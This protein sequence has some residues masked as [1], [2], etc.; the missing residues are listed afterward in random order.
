MDMSG[1]FLESL[2]LRQ[3]PELMCDQAEAQNSQWRLEALGFS[4]SVT[5]M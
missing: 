5:C 2:V 4:F 1:M 3:H